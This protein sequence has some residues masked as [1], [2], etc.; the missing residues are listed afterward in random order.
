MKK[1]KILI[2]DDAPSNIHM[3]NIMLKDDYSIIVAK[4]GKKAIELAN[5]MPQPDL[6]LLDVV[7]PQMD[8]FE[9][10]KKLKED[11][12]TQHIPIIFVSSLNDKD[13]QEQAIQLGGD[14]YVSKP[15]VKDILQNKI[16]TQLNMIS[17]QKKILSN[18]TIEDIYMNNKTP[19]ILIVDDAPGNIQV[20]L[21]ILKDEYTVSVATSGQKALNMLEESSKPDLILLDI[22]M[23]E[24]DGFELCKRLK[25]DLRYSDIP[26]IFLTVLENEHDMINGL[27]LGAVDYVTKPFEPKVLKARVNTHVKLKLYYDELLQNLKDKEKILIEQSKLA[28]LGEMFENITHQWKQPLSVI[29]MVSSTIKLEKQTDGLEDSELFKLLDSIDNSV[30]YLTSTVDDFRDFLIRDNPQE[31]FKVKTVVQNTLKLLDSK[32]KYENIDITIDLDEQELFN[33]KNDLIQVLM[34]IFTNA[35]NILKQKEDQRKIDISFDIDDEF[36]I[37]KVCDNGGGIDNEIINKVFD[38]HFTTK[39]HEKSSGLGLYMS[40]RIV[41]DYINGV[42]EVKSEDNQAIFMIKLPL[43]KK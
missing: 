31:F 24:M 7:M 19:K 43:V 4:D 14:D 1:K 38:K 35:I 37:L 25:S 12:Y 18:P 40:K 36:Y 6:I 15:V 21:E 20:A 34:N 30:T 27:E 5:K 2:V 22:I 33:F 28:I 39:I 26:I 11:I 17:D 3:L 29:G 9:V 42:L 13:E 16:K 23:P 8:G 41:E 10:C 32:I